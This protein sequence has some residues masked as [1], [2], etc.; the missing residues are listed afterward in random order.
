MLVGESVFVY[1]GGDVIEGEIYY[2]AV[3][4]DYIPASYDVIKDVCDFWFLGVFPPHTKEF[5]RVREGIAVLQSVLGCGDCFTAPADRVFRLLPPQGEYPQKVVPFESLLRDF[6]KVELKETQL[7]GGVRIFRTEHI[8]TTLR[9]GMMSSERVFEWKA[10]IS[11]ERGNGF[12]LTT[13]EDLSWEEIYSK[14]V[15]KFTFQR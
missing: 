4:V 3:V 12:Y 5:G 14:A 11:Q 13:S 15:K 7:I 2:E 6:K 9:N 8:T 10:E 1:W